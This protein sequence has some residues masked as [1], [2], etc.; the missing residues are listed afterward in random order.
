MVIVLR[1]PEVRAVID[2]VRS[3]RVDRIATTVEYERWM[4]SQDV[5]DDESRLAARRDH[6][7]I[8]EALRI[9]RRWYSY[10][11]VHVGSAR[12]GVID[13]NACS[14]SPIGIE[15]QWQR[16]AAWCPLAAH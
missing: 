12:A 15:S 8:L 4:R 9:S 1:A 7:D 10:N 3:W 2:T 16:S 6:G 13:S 11:V 5:S 14:N